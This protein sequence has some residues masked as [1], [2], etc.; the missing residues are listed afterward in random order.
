MF[1][2]TR[3]NRDLQTNT[4]N[5]IPSEDALLGIINEQQQTWQERM[6]QQTEILMR[7]IMEI[8]RTLSPNQIHQRHRN[9]DNS[10]FST[11]SLAIDIESS[12]YDDSDAAGSEIELDA[13]IKTLVPADQII[14]ADVP[15][16]RTPLRAHVSV[17]GGTRKP[18][19]QPLASGVAG[20]LSP[21][22]LRSPVRP[23]S[24][25]IGCNQLGRETVL[26]ECRSG[27]LAQVSGAQQINR[28]HADRAIAGEADPHAVLTS[29]K[30][31]ALRRE[32]KRCGASEV[33]IEDA[34]DSSDAK[35][36]LVSLIVS[37][38]EADATK[39][40]A[41][42]AFLKISELRSRAKKA[43]VPEAKIEEA[44]DSALPK[45]ALINLVIAA[46]AREKGSVAK[47]ARVKDLDVLELEPQPQPKHATATSNSKAM[48]ALLS[49]L[50]SGK[51]EEAV[52][53]IEEKS[54]TDTER[55]L[56]AKR[57]I[58]TSQM[59]VTA[60]VMLGTCATTLLP[61]YLIGAA[62]G[63]VAEGE[64]IVGGIS[65]N[66]AV[67]CGVFSSLVVVLQMELWAGAM[68]DTAFVPGLGERILRPIVAGIGSFFWFAGN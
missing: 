9:R 3:S 24:V 19:L 32:A 54:Q 38:K 18:P 5:N 16:P 11:D 52:A 26:T 60:L 64:G 21:R 59:A 36:A 48:D 68:R 57:T 51:L 31:S 28:E 1:T 12:A 29:M 39:L 40:G 6:N 20:S 56:V 33:E 46:T 66:F 4:R 25:K 55:I 13:L 50:R 61:N 27:E 62:Y 2:A 35:G 63:A 23:P 30:I 42:L 45:Q 67:R 53:K 7:P 15:P 17:G 58:R 8:V 43:N 65:L 22:R 44:G 47:L 49:G 37:K 41:E 10:D 34:G 14:E